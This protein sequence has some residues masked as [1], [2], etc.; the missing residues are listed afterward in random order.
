MLSRRFRLPG[1]CL[2]QVLGGQTIFNEANLVI[3]VLPNQLKFGRVA[4][5]ISAKFLPL[6]VKR[7]RLKRQLTAVIDP[8]KIAPGFDF[9]V[10]VRRA[11]GTIKQ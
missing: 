5:V 4:V 8:A 2:P 6:A 7:N 11:R 3:K 10:L 1:Y 9:V